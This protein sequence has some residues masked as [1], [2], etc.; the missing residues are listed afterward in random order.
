[1]GSAMSAAMLVRMAVAYSPPTHK[2]ITVA[3]ID[4]AQGR[5]ALSNFAAAYF[6]KWL[7]L[8][9]N[10]CDIVDVFCGPNLK[11][12]Y[13]KYIPILGPLISELLSNPT[14]HGQMHHFMLEDKTF[15]QQ[16]SLDQCLDWIKG[17]SWKAA[18]QMMTMSWEPPRYRDRYNSHDDDFRDVH[19]LLGE[20]L[21]WALHAVQDS[22]SRAHTHRNDQEVITR[23]F[24]WDDQ[25]SKPGPEAG[26]GG[27]EWDEGRNC[28]GPGWKGHEAYD[29]AWLKNRQELD[30]TVP[31]VR[32]AV[33]ASADLLSLTFTA[34]NSG[35]EA[36]RVFDA[37]MNTFLGK[38]FVAHFTE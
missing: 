1:M 9:V 36:R 7:P 25:N 10:Q 23:I 31:H 27:A 13:Y 20:P 19:D 6:R 34:G 37:R 28:P 33:N 26:K 21:A 35:G 32:A 30:Y 24:A 8:A 15:P 17:Q 38:Y 14:H 18:Q 3:A 12:T 16:K 22:F 5:R 29:N 11:E 2:G 4:E